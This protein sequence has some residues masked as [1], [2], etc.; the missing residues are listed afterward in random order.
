MI[1]ADRKMQRFAKK[2]KNGESYILYV[3]T[4]LNGKEMVPKL[5][6]LLSLK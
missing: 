3:C 1:P 2:L 6:V 5:N 4:S